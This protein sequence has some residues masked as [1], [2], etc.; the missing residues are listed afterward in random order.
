MLPINTVKMTLNIIYSY[1]TSFKRVCFI[2]TSKEL[3]KKQPLLL[4]K[5]VC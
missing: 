5:S 3:P 1:Y 4:W 2:S